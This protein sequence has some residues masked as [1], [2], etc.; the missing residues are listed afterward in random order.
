MQKV[1]QISSYYRVGNLWLVVFAENCI[2]SLSLES[3]NP[4]FLSFS[5]VVLQIVSLGRIYALDLICSSLAN[6]ARC[7]R[8]PLFTADSV[9][10]SMAHQIGERRILNTLTLIER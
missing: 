1:N 2:L 3:N 9:E 4:G 10:F 7:V 6:H 8:W 5:A